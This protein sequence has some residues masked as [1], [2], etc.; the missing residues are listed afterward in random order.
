VHVFYICVYIHHHPFHIDIKTKSENEYYFGT[1]R[2]RE[3]VIWYDMTLVF[4]Y[5]QILIIQQKI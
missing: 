1:E 2:A 5:G 4:L 3:Y